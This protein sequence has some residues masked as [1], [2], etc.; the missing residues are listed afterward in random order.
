VRVAY[1]SSYTKPVAAHAPDLDFRGG[2]PGRHLVLPCEVLGCQAMTWR[3]ATFHPD[4]SDLSSFLLQFIELILYVFFRRKK[5]S[6][7]ARAVGLGETLHIQL[8]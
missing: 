2:V 1:D 3:G 7:A 4:Y 8:V 6:V 5:E